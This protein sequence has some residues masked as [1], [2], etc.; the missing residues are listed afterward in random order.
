MQIAAATPAYRLRLASEDEDLVAAQRL[1]YAVFNVE[2][3]EGLASSEATGRDEDEFDAVCDHLLVE[4]IERGEAVGTY[5]IQTGKRAAES[6][7]GYYSAREFEF[8]PFESVRGQVIEL[9]RACVAAEHRNPAV[10]GLLWR[11]IAQYAHGNGARYLT[12]CSSLTSQDE[13]EGLAVY[14]E[15]EARYLVEAA[16]RTSPLPELRCRP[17]NEGQ[18]KIS[19]VGKVPRLMATYL[20]LG[21][22]ICGEPAIDR[23]FGTIDFLTWMDLEGSA[24]R[25]LRKYLG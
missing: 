10:L 15:L 11:G 22:K 4:E 25:T 3:H 18:A 1:R 21:A 5:R 12:G 14:A 8:A 19:G 23:T 9:G 20:M 24:A 16:W 17:G 6:G 2:M 13:A 7:L